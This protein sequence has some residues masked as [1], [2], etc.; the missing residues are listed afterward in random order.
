[1]EQAL[2]LPN[3]PPSLPSDFLALNSDNIQF[4][5]GSYDE[6]TE[7]CYQS[8]QGQIYGPTPQCF[9]G[10]PKVI[11][12]RNLAPA[13][14]L[15][16]PGR[17]PPPSDC[18]P[19]LCRSRPLLDMSCTGFGQ[20]GVVSTEPP[21]SLGGLPYTVMHDPD[22]DADAIVTWNET[23]KEA[24]FLWKWVN[25]VDRGADFGVQTNRIILV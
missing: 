17:L 7:L 19:I 13:T 11:D 8:F 3:R 23:S 15:P 5:E 14:D 1:L 24:I 22:T 4:P 12:L 20:D 9:A 16:S 18:P 2:T 21:A 10:S 6:T 25:A